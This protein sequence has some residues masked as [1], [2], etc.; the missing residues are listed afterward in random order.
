MAFSGGLAHAEVI[1]NQWQSRVANGNIVGK[2]SERVNS[3]LKSLKTDFNKRTAGSLMLREKNDRLKKIIN[4][5]RTIATS[6]FRQ[7]LSILET[8]TINKFRKTLIQIAASSPPSEKDKAEDPSLNRG[9]E[10]QALRDAVF[11]FK[12]SVA[13]LESEELGFSSAETI[14]LLTESLETILKEFPESAAYK[15]EE[16]KKLIKETKKP[17]PKK[18]KS[19]AFNIALNLVGMLRPPGFGN[20]QGFIG[21]ATKIYTKYQDIPLDLMLGFQNDGDSP[22]VFLHHILN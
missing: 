8:R 12:A 4:Y 15:L 9:K 10:Q 11:D 13:D 19:R 17:K 14:L 21:Y 3:L 20:L 18:K 6:I 16:I 2:F 22:E 7:Q 1:I 5:V